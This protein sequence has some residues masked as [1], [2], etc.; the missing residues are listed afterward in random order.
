MILMVYR[1]EVLEGVFFL[2]NLGERYFSVLIILFCLVIC[3]VFFNCVI[4]KFINFINFWWVIMMLFGFRF[5]CII[6]SLWVVF[7]FFNICSMILVVLV[8]GNLFCKVR[9]LFKVC[10]LIYFMMMKWV[11][12]I[13]W[14]LK[15]VVILG[16]EIWVDK[17]VLLWK[18]LKLFGLFI[19]KGCNILIVIVWFKC[20][21]VVLYMVFIFFFLMCL[22]I[23][24]LESFLLIMIS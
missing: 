19:K 4:L 6:F 17:W 11:F 9:I 14:K 21:L 13:F 16:W 12:L 8:F 15:S 2:I 7:N 18:C 24:K 1:L 20:R 22:L 5:W 10:F 23:W 3:F